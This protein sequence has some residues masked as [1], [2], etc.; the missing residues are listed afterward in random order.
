[1][2][3]IGGA[4][5]SH[6]AT[7]FPPV[8]ESDFPGGFMRRGSKLIFAAAMVLFA[9]P[10]FAQISVPEIPFDSTPNLLKM[11]DNIVLGDAVRVPT[12]SKG[13]IYFYM[14]VCALS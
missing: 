10:L 3:G 8:H 2:L 6:F 14:R 4:K 13:H 9:S 11:S 5:D 12:N 1:M 7:S